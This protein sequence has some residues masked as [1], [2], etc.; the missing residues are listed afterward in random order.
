MTE[1]VKFASGDPEKAILLISQIAERSAF[2]V[3]DYDNPEHKECRV[4]GFTVKIHIREVSN[5]PG[6]AQYVHG[7]VNMRKSINEKNGCSFPHRSEVSYLTCY[8]YCANFKRS[9]MQ[10]ATAEQVIALRSEER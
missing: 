9:Y 2:I 6:V 7:E 10:R 8:P 1:V 4:L 3:F 5:P